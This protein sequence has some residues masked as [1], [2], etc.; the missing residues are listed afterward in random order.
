MSLNP[1]IPE[2]LHPD[3]RKEKSGP[4]RRKGSS[5]FQDDTVINLRSNIH[6]TSLRERKE[7]ENHPSF[8]N[9]RERQFRVT[10]YEL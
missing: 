4:M 2:I 1:L 5:G 6:H 7:R 8:V 3:W 10:S 9:E